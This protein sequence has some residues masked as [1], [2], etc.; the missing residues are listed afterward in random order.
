MQYDLSRCLACGAV[1]DRRL[2]KVTVVAEPVMETVGTFPLNAK[3]HQGRQQIERRL[4]CL[5]DLRG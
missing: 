2:D 3:S 4:R 1:F 5:Q